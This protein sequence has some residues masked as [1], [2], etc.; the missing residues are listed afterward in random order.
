MNYED[1]VRKAPAYRERIAHWNATHPGEYLP[2]EPLLPFE[3][4]A[5]WVYEAFDDLMMNRGDAGIQYAQE[6]LHQEG[7]LYFQQCFSDK[8][9]VEED[10]THFLNEG[11]P[12][13]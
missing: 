1:M 13:S 11:E 7:G 8:L 9:E 12:E 3:E 6:S 4:E 5:D 10:F 2:K